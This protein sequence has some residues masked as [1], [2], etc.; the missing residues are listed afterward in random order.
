MERNNG[1]EGALLLLEPGPRVAVGA[2]DARG[3]R[4]AA[5]DAIKYRAESVWPPQGLVVFSHDRGGG[6]VWTVV[7]ELKAGV[8]VP[9]TEL[10]R[11]LRQDEPGVTLLGVVVSSRDAY[12]RW[13]VMT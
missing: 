13:N 1:C 2:V 4:L 8:L 7:A 3:A 6:R 5:N 12:G 10:L 11:P 9:C